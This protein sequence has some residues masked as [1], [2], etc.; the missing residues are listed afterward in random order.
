MPMEFQIT[1]FEITCTYY[2]IHATIVSYAI[3]FTEFVI[4]C[5]SK[6]VTGLTRVMNTLSVG[7]CS[8]VFSA[9]A[10]SAFCDDKQ[11][12]ECLQPYQLPQSRQTVLKV[13]KLLQ[14]VKRCPS[15]IRI[16]S[17]PTVYWS[18][19][20]NTYFSISPSFSDSVLRTIA[21]E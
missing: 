4:I 6:S 5:R 9:A 10:L 13:D 19:E 17:R 7:F 15:L 18:S 20:C 14:F 3:F 21:E 12:H 2:P 11:V 8:H 16:Y 1:S